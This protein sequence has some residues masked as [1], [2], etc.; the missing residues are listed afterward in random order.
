MRLKTP[1]TPITSISPS[2]MGIHNAASYLK[3]AFPEAIALETALV[4]PSLLA[5]VGAGWHR[6]ANARGW[7]APMLL[8][9]CSKAESEPAPHVWL[10]DIACTVGSLHKPVHTCPCHVRSWR[11]QW[12]R[13]SRP[14]RP[15]AGRMWGR[16]CPLSSRQATQLRSWHLCP[17]WQVCACSLF[18]GKWA[19]LEP[20]A[21]R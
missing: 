10:S 5:Q 8:A 7:F 18:R 16:C 20:R 12:R 6:P 17:S 13:L 14:M 2:R 11:V 3:Q 21:S 9:R 4:G 15:P 1:R 19:C